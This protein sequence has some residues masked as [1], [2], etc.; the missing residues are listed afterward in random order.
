VSS[1]GITAGQLNGTG[2]PG[3]TLSPQPEHSNQV[4]GALTK[5]LG[6]GR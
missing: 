2:S 6:C 5:G 1:P 4:A 3:S